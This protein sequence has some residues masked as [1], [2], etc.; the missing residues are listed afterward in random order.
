[1]PAERQPPFRVSSGLP[2]PSNEGKEFVRPGLASWTHT[3]HP[4]D[5]HRRCHW[6]RRLPRLPSLRLPA[7]AGAARGLRR[8]P[9]HELAREHRAHPR[10]GV[11]LRE[12]RPDGA[13]R[14][15]RAGRL[16]LPLRG[17][18][19]P[20]RLPADAAALAQGGLLRHPQRP[21]PGQVQARALPAG[22][23]ERGLRRPG[24]A[25]AEGDVLGQRQPDRPARRLR[26]GQALRRGADDGV[27]QPAG[28]GHR[29]RPDLQHVR[30]AHAAERRPRDPDLR[31][32]GAR[33]TSRSRCSATGRRRGASA[34]STT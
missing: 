9:R 17:P 33:R 19:E 15:R 31:A 1:M 27:P 7:R 34:T 18:R 21:R 26:R 12:P 11:H 29:D 8:Q 13:P 14:A 6:R 30:A 3:Y 10:R 4:R 28:R 5:A 22:L 23:D 16:R 32:P 20:D 25:P 2:D 24:G